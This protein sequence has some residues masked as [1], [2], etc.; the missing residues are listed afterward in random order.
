[1]NIHLRI[2]GPARSTL[3]HA[4]FEGAMFCGRCRHCRRYEPA[5]SSCHAFKPSPSLCYPCLGDPCDTLYPTRLNKPIALNAGRSWEGWET[6]GDSSR[7]GNLWYSATAAYDSVWSGNSF[8]VYRSR[9]S[10]AAT[11][12]ISVSPPAIAT[13]APC[14]SVMACVR[15]ACV[16]GRVCMCMGVRLYC[17]VV[18]FTCRGRGTAELSVRSKQ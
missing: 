2:Y 12:G 1:M 7:T 6:V 15:A 11:D 8:N 9:F 5:H 17:M 16:L 10:L 14:M 4:G 3:G 18:L 13:C